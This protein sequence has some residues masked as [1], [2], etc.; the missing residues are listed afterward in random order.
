MKKKKKK[1]EKN[2]HFRTFVCQDPICSH[3]NPRLHTPK[4]Y[5]KEKKENFGH[6]QLKTQERMET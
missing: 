3:K 6:K 1:N 2:C 5:C 4:L